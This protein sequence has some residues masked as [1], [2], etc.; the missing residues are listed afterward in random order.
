MDNITPTE[1]RK[2]IIKDFAYFLKSKNVYVEFRMNIINSLKRQYNDFYLNFFY[3]L[4]RKALLGRL[5]RL[6]YNRATFLIFLAFYWKGTEQG[7]AFWRKLNE[8]WANYV[9]QHY[10]QYSILLYTHNENNT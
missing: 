5:E 6:T 3:G 7:D 9:K 10:E 8:E 2:Q 4:E 1:I